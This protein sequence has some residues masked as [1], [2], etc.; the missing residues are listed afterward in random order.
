MTVGKKITDLTASGSLKDTNLVIV[1]DGN[2]TKRST[3]TQLGEY[4]GTKFSN[5]NL[6]IN[7]DFKINQRGQTSYTAGGFNY[8][9]DRWRSSSKTVTVSDS[10]LTIQT[11]D[12]AWF[13][14]KLEKAIEENATL[15]IKVSAIN[16]KISLS[17]PT[18]EIF[19]T[20][21]GVY[22]ITLSNVEEFNL[23]LFANTSV[24]IEWT[25]L[26]KG[27]VATPFV[28]PNPTDEMLK[29]QRYYRVYSAWKE[30]F[31]Y[32]G[33]DKLILF[34]IPESPM[35]VDPTISTT[36]IQIV[37]LQ[38]GDI[39][40]SYARYDKDISLSYA[41]ISNGNIL[42]FA[43]V[44]SVITNG[45]IVILQDDLTLNAEIY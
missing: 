45:G 37:G 42:C 7:P 33:D 31:T 2:G 3:L 29:C 17:P 24:T 14:Q 43:N 19:I 23:Y 39:G 34:T 5:P 15:S 41:N 22:S 26:E 8:T 18:N 20:S 21:P 32:R 40:T 36:K 11:D 9:V 6:L 1:H 4:M 44:G 38:A 10:G 27:T 30:T 28:A 12:E 13:T 25:K 16:G 35:R